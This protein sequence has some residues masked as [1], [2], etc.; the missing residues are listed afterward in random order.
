M[1]FLKVWLIMAS[2][3]V[4]ITNAGETLLTGQGGAPTRYK[5]VKIGHSTIVI[6]AIGGSCRVALYSKWIR[7]HT[8]L[9]ILM[10]LLNMCVCAW[11]CV[12]RCGVT[13]ATGKSLIWL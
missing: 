3:V 1:S 11:R 7:M 2:N 12:N 10:E 13:S 5:C 8:V 9:C 4:I 6:S